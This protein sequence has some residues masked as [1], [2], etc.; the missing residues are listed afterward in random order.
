MPDSSTPFRPLARVL[1]GQIIRW[2]MVC[3]VLMSMVQTV[4]EFRQGK[5]DFEATVRGFSEASVP[6]LSISLWDIEPDVVDKQL[7]V[8]ARR[9]E[10][11]FVSLTTLTGKTFEAGDGTQRQGGTT[12][13]I[14]VPSPKG[15]GNIGTLQITANDAYLYRKITRAIGQLLLGY[16]VFVVAICLTTAVLLRRELQRPLAHVA[17]FAREL[18]PAKIATLVQVSRNARAYRDEVDV[19]TDGIRQLQA[20]IAAHVADLDQL[21]DERTRELALHNLILDQINQMLP[22]PGVLD[23]LAHQIEL[24]H[25]GAWC[26]IYLLDHDGGH[27]RVAAAPS[28][29]GFYRE[30]MDGITLGPQAGPCA[31]AIARKTSVFEGAKQ[32][33]EPAGTYG[34]L[35]QRADLHACWAQPIF[36]T[37]GQVL[38]VLALHY[39]QAMQACDIDPVLLG[40]YAKLAMLAIERKRAEEKLRTL[41][42][43]VEQ[44]PVSIVI[45]DPQGRVQ[46]VN[47][48]FEQLTGFTSLEAIGQN[49]QI[50]SSEENTPGEHRA[51]WD[52]VQAGQTWSGEFHSRRKDGSLFW[53]HVSISPI[54]D[55]QGTLIH[56][57]AV[58]EDITRDK[59][60]AL[61]LQVAKNAAEAANVAKSQFLATMSHEIRTPM[62]GIL[63]MAQLLLVP[64]LT[65]AK[66]ENYTRTVL[67][68]G[69]TLLTLLND[70]LDLSKVEA[71]KLELCKEVFDPA[72]LVQETGALFTQLAASKGLQLQAAWVGPAGRRYRA[73]SSRL[74]QMLSNLIGN[75]IKFTAQGFV[76]AVVTEVE[77]TADH[78]VLEFSVLDSGIGI[79]PEKQGLL[80]KPFT[81]ADSSTTREYGGS[82]LGL[83]IVR[84]LA[85]LM[86]GTVGLDST[87]G[88]GSRFWFRVRVDTL[89]PDQNSRQMVRDTTTLPA[90]DVV[91]QPA[92]L[93]LVVEDNAIN[94]MVVEGMLGM[95]GLRFISVEDGQLAV[96]AIQAGLRPDVVLMD[97]QMP[98]MDGITATRQIRQWELETQRASLPIVALTAGAFETDRDHCIAAGMNEF[99]TKPVNI[100]DLRR[101][102]AQWLALRT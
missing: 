72:Q 11:A 37:Q 87:P 30:A 68:S 57:L 99:M 47:P 58:K 2:A 33:H 38:G 53:E 84:S 17:Q 62:N 8:M 77:C 25:P 66:R 36:D 83:S 63:G 95:L 75:A 39:R 70:I 79:A 69:Q 22:L 21:V 44:S 23:T 60:V 20:T 46:Y 96:N 61:E 12:S 27:L 93:V 101:V 14:E 49:T 42:R 64:G 16:L 82:G 94:R 1:I 34:E 45:S 59:E 92:G 43:A 18:D 88:D 6:L 4:L 65:E 5:A 3:F 7:A 74:R 32:P 52:L 26:G 102:L 10:I 80:F 35:A 97:M 71:G 19:L 76:H 56:F 67:S 54:I 85:Q 73:D 15:T 91:D 86:D 89:L 9:P 40:R 81:Q 55:E 98:V 51:M 78:S 100:K 48:R 31:A 50:L 13:R 41:S 28:L 90:T 24:A 29:P